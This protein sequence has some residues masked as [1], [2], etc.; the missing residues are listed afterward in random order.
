MHD[1]DR[2]G[3]ALKKFKIKWI[4]ISA[5][6]LTELKGMIYRM[7]SHVKNGR[8]YT[9]VDGTKESHIATI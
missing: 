9:Y 4:F 8:K 6:L 1:A 7:K 2:G 5:V 3:H